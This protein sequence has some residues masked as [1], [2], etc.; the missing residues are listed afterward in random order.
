MDYEHL[1]GGAIGRRPSIWPFSRAHPAH[2]RGRARAGRPPPGDGDFILQRRVVLSRRRR[3]HLDGRLLLLRVAAAARLA[4]AVDADGD[5]ADAEE[6]DDDD[7]GDDHRDER[8][9]VEDARLL[10]PLVREVVELALAGARAVHG[11]E[12]AVGA[13]VPEALVLPAAVTH[14]CVSMLPPP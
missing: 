5:A 3:R 8:A 11:L 13:P 10:L 12:A 4:A 7:G 6:E 9:A 2:I 14:V 1:F